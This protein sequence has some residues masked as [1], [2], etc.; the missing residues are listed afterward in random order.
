LLLLIGIR[1][2]LIPIQI[3]IAQYQSPKPQ[4][5]FVLGGGREREKAAAKLA[6]T[7]PKLPVWIS[8]GGPPSWTK[9]Y[10]KQTGIS[11]SRLHLNFCAVDTVTN[12]TCLVD[13]FNQRD[14][15]HVYLLT[16]NFHLSRAQ[17]IG[18]LVFGSHGIAITPLGISSSSHPET[19]FSTLRDS[20]RSIVWIFTGR[21]FVRFHPRGRDRV[22]IPDPERDRIMISISAN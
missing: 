14:I 18:F 2:S 19:W 7:Y 16:S 5:I 13:E 3:A 9:S 6:K 15:Q 11:L 10:F 1:I 22:S 20:I 8:S 4:A 21:T 12:F 17:V